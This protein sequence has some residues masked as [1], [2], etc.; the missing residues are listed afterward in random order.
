MIDSARKRPADV[1]PIPESGIAAR[2]AALT[3][4]AIPRSVAP[5]DRL[6]PTRDLLNLIGASRSTLYVLI[7]DGKFPPPIKQGTRS[8]W[9]K[10]DA[11]NYL[12]AR[13]AECEAA[14]WP[15]KVP[16]PAKTARSATAARG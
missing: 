16:C 12:K 4:A 9:L 13:L 7:R 6:L 8:R 5:D 11:E 15:P 14:T 10:S 2:A 1:Y 3:S